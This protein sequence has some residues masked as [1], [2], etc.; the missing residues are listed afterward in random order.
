[1]Y[2]FKAMQENAVYPLLG[3]ENEMDAGFLHEYIYSYLI[4]LKEYFNQTAE[5]GYAIILYFS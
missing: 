2:D 3:K 5:K 1:M 4:K